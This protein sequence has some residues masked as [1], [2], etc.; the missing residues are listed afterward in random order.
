M[1]NPIE[2]LRS[3]YGEIPFN[4][5]IEWND[6]LTALLSHRS[7]RSY[8][9]DPLSAGTLELLIAAAQSASTSSN[10]QTWSV[11]AVEDPE[12]KEELSKLAGNQA[13]IKQVPLFLVWLADLARLSYVADSRGISHDALEYLEMFVMAT[14]DATLAAQNAA[15][16][17]ESLGLGTVYIGGIR[18]RPQEVAEIL[19]LPSSVYAVFGL[20]VGYPNPEVEAAIKPRLPQSAV[21]HRET[22]KLSEQEEAIAHYNEII[23][24]FYTEQKMNI[25]GDW[26]EHSAQRIATVESLRGRDRLREVL[27]HLGFKLL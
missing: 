6:S 23:K 8:L 22:Y 17:A 3:R 9:S 7:I 24:E 11:V 20:C 5:E 13:H 1:T 10:L 18:N 16:A 26:S 25:P 14:I 2:L 15:V 21:L 4:P 19:N 12:R 27:N